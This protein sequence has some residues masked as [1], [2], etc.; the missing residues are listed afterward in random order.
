MEFWDPSGEEGVWSPRFSK[1]SKSFNDWEVEGRRLIPLL[2]DR[3]LWKETSNGIFS[4]KSLYNDLAS[5]RVDQF[6]MV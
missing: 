5:R 4:V 6:L 1:P 3:M 2:E